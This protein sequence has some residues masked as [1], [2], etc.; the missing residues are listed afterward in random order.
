MYS[1][2]RKCLDERFDELKSFLRRQKYPENLITAGI[3]QA[4]SLD[5]RSVR[6]M[7]DK[8]DQTLITYVSTHNPMNTEIFNDIQND[9]QVLKRDEHMK[10]GL[11]PY[12]IIK[13]KRQPKHLK[14]LLKRAKY[15]DVEDN[16]KVL[17]CNRS[18]CGLCL[19]LIE[20]EELTFKCGRTMK[21]SSVFRAM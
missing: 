13:S 17:R 12:K 19:H 4:K 18:N 2:R 16:P 21:L 1:I 5:Q 9:L 10:E 7:K 15:T 8:D 14:K 11:E 20:G 6:T 3:N